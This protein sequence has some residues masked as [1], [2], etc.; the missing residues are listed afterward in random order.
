MIARVFLSFFL[1]LEGCSSV[2]NCSEINKINGVDIEK[3]LMVDEKSEL[4]TRIHS[5]KE[6]KKVEAIPYL[7]KYIDDVRVTHILMYKGMTIGRVAKGV[8][9]KLKQNIQ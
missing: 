5:L 3:Y 4:V 1:F 7:E 8:I 9:E 2:D 6:C